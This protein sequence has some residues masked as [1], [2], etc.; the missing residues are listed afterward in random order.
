MQTRAP[1]FPFLLGLSILLLGGT[2]VLKSQNMQTGFGKNRVQY[3]HHQED[4]KYYETP[5][6]TTYWYG[7][8]QNIAIPALQLAEGHYLDIQ[9]LLEYELNEPI[10]LLVFTDLSDLKQ[11]NIGADE[12]FLV[13]SGETKVSGNKMFVYYNGDHQLLQQQIREGIAGILLNAMLLGGN[14]QEIVQNS[15]LLNMPDW[16][17]NGLKAYCGSAWNVQRDEE[18]RQVLLAEEATSFSELAQKFPTL[19]GHA[20]WQYIAQQ[21][22][23]GTISN[24]LYLTRINRGLDAGFRYVMGNGYE[25]TTELVFE[26]YQQRAV[27]DLKETQ[28]PKASDWVKV[29]NK[30]KLPLFQAKISPDGQQIAWVQNDIG[31]WKVWVQNLQTGKR[32]KVLRGGI[33]N[34]QQATDYDYPLLAWSPDRQTLC[35]V[36]EQRDVAKVA[37]LNL[38]TGARSIEPASPEFQRIHSVEFINPFDLVFSATARGYTDLYLYRTKTRQTERLTQDIWDDRDATFLRLPDARYLVF[39]SNRPADTLSP[40]RFDSL[41]PVGQWDLFMYNLD[42]R[43]EELIRI[44]DSPLF[45]ERCPVVLDSSHLAWIS[46]ETGIENRVVGQIQDYLAYY[47]TVIYLRNGIELNAI[48]PSRMAEWSLEKATRVHPLLQEVLRNVDSS[49][50]DSLR[51]Y[52]VYKKKV[53]SWLDSQY[54]R[55]ISFLSS[56]ASNA[57]RTL[58]TQR[59]GRHTYFY[60]QQRDTLAPSLRGVKY[61]LYRQQTLADSG[62]PTSQPPQKAP[63]L[64]SPQLDSFPAG[65][66]FQVPDY[67]RQPSPSP[68][69][70]R[71]EEASPSMPA[72]EQAWNS[73]MLSRRVRQVRA[74]NKAFTRFNPSRTVGYRLRFRTDFITTDMDNSLLFEGL[75]SYA[76][77]PGGFRTPAPGLLLRANFKELLENYQVEAGFRLPTSFNGSEYYLWMEDRKKR[78]DRR[79]TLYRKST[80]QTLENAVGNPYQLRYNTL[81]GQYEL[82]YPF[83]PFFSLRAMATL[84]QDKQITLSSDRK[85]LEAPDYAEQR[86]ALR[87]AAVYDNTLNIDVNI[88]NGTRARFYVEAVK[89]FEFNTSPDWSLRLNSGFMTVLNLDARHYQRLDRYSILAT[90]LAAATTFGSE[91]ILY[92]LGG[93]DNWIIPQFST[94]IP[95][96]QTEVFAYETLAANLRGFQQ[97]IRNGGSF[98]L[99]NTEL[100]IPLFKYLLRR[101]SLGNF[102]RNFQLVGFFDAGTAWTGSSPYNKDNPINI[103]YLQNPPTVSMRVNYF[104]DPLV[105]GYGAGLR[106]QLFGLFLRADYAWGIETQQVRKP[107][108]H[109]ALG[110][111]F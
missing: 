62:L 70:S 5:H 72:S 88:K 32:T 26:H 31:K 102:W 110:V 80:V 44:T 14:L 99:L 58:E 49:Q 103:V 90:R 96:P 98:A 89:R 33:R 51:S 111:D 50:V 41:L 93:V 40:V 92:Y 12:L 60:L 54:G 91:R 36:F 29:K 27:E 59:K 107:M 38:T 69:G 87:L 86:A 101:P 66:S 74:T 65:W 104:K 3:H 8:A 100:R 47:K 109:L 24:L 83:D 45:K 57:V 15:V 22:G 73:K 108:L 64:E 10:E 20:F 13:K 53:V 56:Y 19:A 105:A 28:E 17:I 16:Y 97:N 63:V 11:S 71:I 81:L 75:D 42:T 52:P 7:E 68:T 95:A 2:T 25:R 76:A 46:D 94:Q 37:L 30:R 34:A 23:V 55:G 9:Q 18:L 43:S 67:L 4:W 1:F 21:F 48:D 84:R 85:T 78:I 106:V 79:Y 82:K 77:S 35:V 6:F 39:A 61:T